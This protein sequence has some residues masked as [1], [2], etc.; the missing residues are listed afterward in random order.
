MTNSWAEASGPKFEKSKL[1]AKKRQAQAILD[2]LT[3]RLK[4]DPYGVTVALFSV[5]VAF[6][7]APAISSAASSSEDGTWDK[8]RLIH[9]M[10]V[11]CETVNYQTR[12]DLVGFLHGAV[13]IQMVKWTRSTEEVEMSVCRNAKLTS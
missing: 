8:C 1:A 6:I 7:M 12:G 10:R 9:R 4:E 5:D 3:K 13:F 11:F 2:L